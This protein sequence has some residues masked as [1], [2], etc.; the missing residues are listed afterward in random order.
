ME[1]KVG[2]KVFGLDDNGKPFTGVVYSVDSLNMLTIDRDDGVSG[3]GTYIFNKDRNGW[4]VSRLG[5]EWNYKLILIEK[6]NMNLK[7][8]VL[9]ALT[10]EPFKSLRRAKITNG[11]DM[12]TE[13]GRELF[14][15]WLFRMNVK[16]FVVDEAIKE[17]LDEVKKDEDK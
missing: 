7:E 16:T 14:I 1:F 4:S 12:L 17:A 9:L 13:E 15:N 5:G 3:N 6:Q 8:S 11:D 10:K 2:D